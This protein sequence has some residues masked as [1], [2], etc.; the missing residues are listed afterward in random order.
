MDGISGTVINEAFRQ[1]KAGKVTINT[2]TQFCR[3]ANKHVSSMKPLF[4]RTN[5]ILE[6]QNDIAYS[7][8]IHNYWQKAVIRMMHQ[9]LIFF[10]LSNE[11]APRFSQEVTSN[12]RI[13]S[14][15]IR[16]LLWWRLALPY[17]QK[18]NVRETDAVDWLKYPVCL[19]YVNLLKYVNFSNHSF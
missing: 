15:K 5:D 1:I 6:E 12:Q 10:E 4:Q 19:H 16:S 3:A 8:S 9:H 13:G 14:G 2:S 17:V 18:Y 11:E 7:R